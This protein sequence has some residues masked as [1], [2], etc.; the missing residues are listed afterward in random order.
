MPLQPFV[1]DLIPCLRVQDTMVVFIL[2]SVEVVI[3]EHRPQI[4]HPSR[5]A[6]REPSY[7]TLA[8][9]VTDSQSLLDF[10]DDAT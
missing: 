6:L 4:L 2:V 7:P 10:Q 3:P 1:E 8:S 5:I 9:E